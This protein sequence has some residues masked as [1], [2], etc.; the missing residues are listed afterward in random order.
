MMYVRITPIFFST[1]FP[2]ARQWPWTKFFL[3]AQMLEAPEYESNAPDKVQKK[4]LN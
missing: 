3:R 2:D 4:R 1:R